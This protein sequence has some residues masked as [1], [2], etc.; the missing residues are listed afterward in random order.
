MDFAFTE[1]QQDLAALAKRILEDKVT[2]AVLREA[3]AAEGRFDKG[4]W[5]ALAEANLLGI[6]LP[7]DFD[8][9]SPRWRRKPWPNTWRGSAI[10]AD[11]RKAGQ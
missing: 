7:T 11:I 1:E 9:F 4:T 8:I 6:S 10:P 2:E 5:E 3:D